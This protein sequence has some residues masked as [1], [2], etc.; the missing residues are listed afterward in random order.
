MK[1][2]LR[3]TVVALVV[4]LLGG[5]GVLIA[6]SVWEQ[7][8]RTI[9]PDMLEL[10]AGVSQHIQ[11]F[12]RVKVKDGRKVWEVSAKDGQYFEEEKTVVVRGAIMEWYLEDG[13]TVG[14]RGDEGRI[15]LDGREVT[16]VELRGDIQVSLADYVVRTDSAA[17]DNDQQTITAMGRVEVSGRALQ[18]NG[19]GLEVDVDRQRLRVLHNV[20]MRIDPEAVSR[21]RSDAPA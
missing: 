1:R 15:V 21:V 8:K 10:V 6:R 13:R 3:F 9:V 16:R 19:D 11:D 12:R 18:L 2:R 17:Y 20:S 7:R 4:V 5:V 14:L